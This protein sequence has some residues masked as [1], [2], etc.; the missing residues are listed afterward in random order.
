MQSAS[1]GTYNIAS[2]ERGKNAAACEQMGDV[3]GLEHGVLDSPGFTETRLHPTAHLIWGLNIS[4]YL[5][6]NIWVFFKMSV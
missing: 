6:I 4:V 5:H 1:N 3:S 2:L